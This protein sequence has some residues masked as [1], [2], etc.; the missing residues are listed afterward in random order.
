MLL[1]ALNCT[2]NVPFHLNG[3][4]LGL[5]ECEMRSIRSLILNWWVTTRKWVLR[6]VLQGK[7]MLNGINNITYSIVTVLKRKEKTLPIS[8]LYTKH[9]KI[10]AQIQR[11]IGIIYFHFNLVLCCAQKSWSKGSYYKEKHYINNNKVY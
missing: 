10:L 6:F 3:H 9:Y 11:S 1:N 4:L 5:D 8:L 7:I 2:N